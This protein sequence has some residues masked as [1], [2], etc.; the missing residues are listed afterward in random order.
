LQ[1]AQL[2]ADVGLAESGRFDQCRHIA[3]SLLQFAEELQ[4]GRFAEQSKEL[5]EFF[6]QLGARDEGGHDHRYDSKSIMD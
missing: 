3:G 4:P 2:A 5:T 1:L 6:Q